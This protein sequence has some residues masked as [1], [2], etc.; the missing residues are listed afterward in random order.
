[1]E[2]NFNEVPEWAKELINSVNE[3]K[4]KVNKTFPDEE[5]KH[6]FS[7]LRDLLDMNDLQLKDIKTK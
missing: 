3:M 7:K 4:E 2:E 5:K 1:M 6:D